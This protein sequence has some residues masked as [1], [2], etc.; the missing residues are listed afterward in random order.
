[1]LVIFALL[2]SAD[3]VF[4]VTLNNTFYGLFDL[5][6][7]LRLEEQIPKLVLSA[8]VFIYAVGYVGLTEKYKDKPLQ[9]FVP[10]GADSLASMGFLIPINLLFAIFTVFQVAFLW[11]SGLMQLPDGMLYSQYA[12]EGFFQ[13]LFVTV[14]NFS[15]ILYYALFTDIGKLSFR[16]RGLLVSLCAFTGVL[17]ASSF[18]RMFLYIGTY[19]YTSLRLCVVTFLSMEVFWLLAAVFFLAGWRVKLGRWIVITGIAF[20]LIMNVTGSAEFANWMHENYFVSAQ[21]QPQGME[22]RLGMYCE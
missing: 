22:M 16:V 2:I 9:V 14:I 1:M 19:G 11:G 8:M 12:R 6:E 13:L 18:Y 3:E 17:A 15:I 20:Y 4:R 5:L 7:H 10:K 21:H